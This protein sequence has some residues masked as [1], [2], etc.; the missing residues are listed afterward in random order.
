MV[1]WGPGSLAP[2]VQTFDLAEFMSDIPQS[3]TGAPFN[4]PFGPNIEV[5]GC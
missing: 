5:I 4:Q 1:A 2:T 3:T